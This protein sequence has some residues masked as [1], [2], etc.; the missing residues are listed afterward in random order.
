M[1]TVALDINE[2]VLGDELLEIAHSIYFI[3]S[4]G[5]VTWALPDLVKME[6]GTMIN[7]HLCV[8]TNDDTER[9]EGTMY[10]L[11]HGLQ[12]EPAE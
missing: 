2:E 11:E 3:P 5:F 6:V 9:M 4:N 7:G 10:V 8:V 12:F 1:T